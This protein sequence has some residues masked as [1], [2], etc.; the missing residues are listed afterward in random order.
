MVVNLFYRF[1][2]IIR[3]S[4]NQMILK[5]LQNN[6]KF[7]C[8]FLMIKFYDYKGK[9]WP[10]STEVTQKLFHIKKQTKLLKTSFVQKLQQNKNNFHIK[11]IYDCLYILGFLEKT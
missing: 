4:P 8:Q 10:K 2:Q 9:I 5:D 11:K 6:L 3:V 1:N 7:M